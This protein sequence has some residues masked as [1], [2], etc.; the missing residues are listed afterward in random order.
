MSNKSKK[1]SI[2]LVL[3]VCVFAGGLTTLYAEEAAWPHTM[4][5]KNGEV[6]EGILVFES[7]DGYFKYWFDARVQWEWGMYFEGDNKLNNGSQMRRGTFALKATLYRDW[8]AEVDLGFGRGEFEVRDAWVK[9]NFPGHNGTMQAGYFKEAFGL[10]RLTSSRMLTF[11]ERAGDGVFEPGR[12]KGISYNHWGRNWAVTTGLYGHDDITENR[13]EEASEPVGV[14]VRATIAPIL[15]HRKIVHLGVAGS[16]RTMGGDDGYR[17]RYRAR[18]ESRISNSG[19]LRFLHTGWIND[20]D[21][22]NRYGVEAG[23][24]Y[25]PFQ[26]QSEYKGVMINRDS[27]LDDPSFYSFYAFASYFL[28]GESRGYDVADGEFAAFDHP[29]NKYGAFQ[30]AVRY[31]Q[32]CLTDEDA[33]IYGGTN[34]NITI[35]LNWYANRNIKVQFNYIITSYDEY[36]DGNGSLIPEDSFSFFGIRL[37]ARI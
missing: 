22:Y 18:P 36:A 30:L 32:T 31:S 8:E 5:L 29:R 14:N 1:G 34:D 17:I 6:Q 37:T 23:V 10:E 26:F 2:L 7:E 3:M 12:H 9:Y 28:T 24:V 15:E 21:D 13:F 35:G 27:D 19:G 33:E 4:E 16:H 11:N 20:V 25:G